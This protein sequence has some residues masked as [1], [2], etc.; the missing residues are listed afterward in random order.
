MR[1]NTKQDN[2]TNLPGWQ[3]CQLVRDLA[4]RLSV[5]V[6]MESDAD[7]TPLTVATWDGGIGVDRLLYV[8]LTTAIRTAFLMHGQVYRGHTDRWGTFRAA[9][10]A[11]AGP[12]IAGKAWHREVR[13]KNGI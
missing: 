11:T 10:D 6:A 4:K 12:P 1:K 2:V 5:P 8:S 7:T 13:S 9:R 3:R